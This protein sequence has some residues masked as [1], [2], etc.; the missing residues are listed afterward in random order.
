MAIGAESMMGTNFCNSCQHFGHQSRPVV[1]PHSASCSVARPA[2]GCH[3]QSN[4][5]Q[6]PGCTRASEGIKFSRR[7]CITSRQFGTFGARA[8]GKNSIVS[9]E[10]D[11]RAR[12]SLEKNHEIRICINKT[13]RKSGSLET[14]E[15]FRSLAPP[16]VTVESC[17]CIGIVSPSYSYTSKFW[18]LKLQRT[19][20]WSSCRYKRTSACQDSLLEG[21]RGER[22][23]RCPL[24]AYVG[25]CGFRIL[26]LPWEHAQE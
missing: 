22:D 6:S 2:D 14:L 9:T 1:A 25:P 18:Y 5:L 17:G 26:W 4:G 7:D 8:V 23:R 24:E 12:K 16:N 20:R 19:R 11:E 13:C 10:R 15:V 3:I 21:W